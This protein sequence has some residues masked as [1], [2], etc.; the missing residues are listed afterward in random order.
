MRIVAPVA[1]T[2]PTNA[3]LTV[4]SSGLFRQFAPNLRH[5]LQHPALLVGLSQ[6][7]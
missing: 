6:L 2:G 1:R 7:S 3:T 5:F 4:P